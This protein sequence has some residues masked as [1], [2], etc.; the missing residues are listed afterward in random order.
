MSPTRIAIIAGEESGDRL[1]GA[2]MSALSARR[3]ITWFG[4]GGDDMVAAGLDPLFPL[5]EIAVNGF[6]AIV[7]RLPQLLARIAETAKAVAAFKPDVLIVIDAPEF[8]HRVAKRLRRALPDVP[9][10]NYVSPTVWAWRP[11]RAKAMRPYVDLILALFPFEPAAHARLGGPKCVYVGHPLYEALRAGRDGSVGEALLVL[12]GSRRGEIDR[13]M[14]LFGEALARLAPEVPVRLLAVPRHRERIEA[15]VADWT[16]KP[17]IL[18]GAEGKRTAFA[19]ARAALAASGT[20]TL[21]LAA[22]RVPMVVAYKL[23]FT[24]RQV[25]RLHRFIPIVTATSMV[26][27]NIVIG[28]NAIPAFLEDEAT[29]EAIAGALEPLLRPGTPERDD[30]A[31]AFDE[32]DAAMRVA[33]SPSE[34]AA[35]A[36]LDLLATRATR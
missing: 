1:G 13:L 32:F 25:K 10:V 36:V 22:A 12:P 35:D 2:L 6:D 34:Q 31:T 9:I 27:A 19:T 21:E 24:Y 29:P 11:G 15:Y 26:L 18:T 28:R 3:D 20:V 17:E 30:Q 5:E 4:V 14:P 16:V 8:N 7:R 33:T 23:D